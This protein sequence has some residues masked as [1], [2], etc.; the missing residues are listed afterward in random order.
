MILIPSGEGDCGSFAK[1][2]V[3]LAQSFTVTTFDMPGMSRSIAPALAMKEVTGPLLATQI[4]GLLNELKIENATFYG[5]SSAGSAALSLAAFHSERVKSVIVHEIP[6]HAVAHLDQLSKMD[7]HHIVNAC[8]HIFGTILNDD[9]NAWEGLG[10]EY[11]ARLDKNYG[12]W[13]RGYFPYLVQL[14]LSNEEFTRSP[15][16]WT[17]GSLT[18]AGLFLD[19]VVRATQAEIDIGLLESKHFPHIKIPET[20]A[21]VR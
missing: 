12:P 9:H 2:A 17:I 15:V 10:S 3:T 14:K 5:C 18:P 20:F 21:E 8:R 11:H 13:L 1:T 16:T 7:E 6:L 19:N 4:I